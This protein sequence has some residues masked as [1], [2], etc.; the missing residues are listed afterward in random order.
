MSKEK[1]S[2]NVRNTTVERKM[3]FFL[4]YYPTNRIV[5]YQ[6]LLNLLK[7]TW[8][9]LLSKIA[10]SRNSYI[11]IRHDFRQAVFQSQ[12]TIFAFHSMRKFIII[13]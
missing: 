7:I 1:C 12:N 3:S 8:H 6:G 4:L 10:T 13:V 2:E 11:D 9:A 5:F